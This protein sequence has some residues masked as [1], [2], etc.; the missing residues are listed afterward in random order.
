MLAISQQL[1]Y[2]RFLFKCPSTGGAV[3]SDAVQCPRTPKTKCRAAM[4]LNLQCSTC[5]VRWPNLIASEYQHAEMLE[6]D[7]LLLEP[8][9]SRY[10]HCYFHLQMHTHPILCLGLANSATATQR[11]SSP[12]TRIQPKNMHSAIAATKQCLLQDAKV[13]VM[14]GSP[15]QLHS[16]ARHQLKQQQPPLVTNASVGGLVPH[17]YLAMQQP[18]VDLAIERDSKDVLKKQMQAHALQSMYQTTSRPHLGSNPTSSN[19]QSAA[20]A[21]IRMHMHIHA[22]STLSICATQWCHSQL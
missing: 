15:L 18:T 19:A 6:H 3:F 1:Y 17:A 10:S 9:T 2:R 12:Y 4:Y 22:T 16:A 21:E 5:L 8:A 14:A 7:V 11:T 13:C 20:A